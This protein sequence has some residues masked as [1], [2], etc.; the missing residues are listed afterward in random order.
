MKAL[1][2][3][4][5]AL[6]GV[7]AVSHAQ[8]PTPYPSRPIKLVVAF[9]AGGAPDT[10][11]RAYAEKFRDFSAGQPVI[12]ENKPGATGSIGA[13]HVAKS[14]PDGHTLLIN[15]SALVINPWVMKPTFDIRKD[16]V[17][18]VRT[19]VTPYLMTISPHLPV[20]NFDEFIAYAKN[21]P[22]KVA[23]G[24]YGL[25]SPPHLHLEMLKKAAGVDILHVP[26][27]T[28]MQ[29]LTD[30]LSGQ[31][32]CS[33]DPP[34]IPLPHVQA[35]KIRAIAHTGAGVMPLFKDITAIGKRYP[36]TAVTGWQAIFAP[37]GTPAP[38]LAKLRTDWQK[39]IL[40]PQI[41]EKIRGFGFEPGGD[42]IDAF[43][44]EILDDYDK[45]GRVIKDNNIRLE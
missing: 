35:G 37:A 5:I 13:D 32:Q 43:A 17:P 14:P 6:T 39:V 8:A 40:D 27:K 7:Q 30:L 34:T 23:C 41:G 22:G 12:V 16:L 36:G 33:I 19:A 29:A 9:A 26:Y 31:V 20:Q 28:Y 11:G 38:I 1:L 24:T 2:L 42:S 3:S 10:M 4:V 44:K 18:V 45:F 25:A 15:S 21:H